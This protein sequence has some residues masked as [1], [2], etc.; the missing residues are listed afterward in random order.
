M[1]NLRLAAAAI[2][3]SLA[4]SFALANG[5][6]LQ[7]NSVT[8]SKYTMQTDTVPG[9]NKKKPKTPVPTPA[10]TPTPTPASAN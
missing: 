1:K 5:H 2:A 4:G 8:V 10:P 6:K 9:K 7:N 3:L